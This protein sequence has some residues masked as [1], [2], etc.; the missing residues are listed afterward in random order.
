[1]RSA[2]FTA[3]CE[4][5]TPLASNRKCRLMPPP[6]TVIDAVAMDLRLIPALP[7]NCHDYC[8]YHHQG[9]TTTHGSSPSS[10][11]TLEPPPST[12]H[13][14][15]LFHMPSVDTDKIPPMSPNLFN[16]HPYTI[17]TAL[18][19]SRTSSTPRILSRDRGI[20]AEFWNQCCTK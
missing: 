18:T 20:S 7:R 9:A 16:H 12:N 2:V 13:Q 1:M 5:S 4:H 15:I 8:L 11:T 17:P 19:R 14:I 6:T 10:V 3:S